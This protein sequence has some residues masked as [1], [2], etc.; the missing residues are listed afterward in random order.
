M[1]KQNNFLQRTAIALIFFGMLLLVVSCKQGSA[2]EQNN[3]VSQ[4]KSKPPK[5]DIHTAVKFHI[6]NTFFHNSLR[7]PG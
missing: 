2:K 6:G 5:V 3:S 7:G 4:T 1:K